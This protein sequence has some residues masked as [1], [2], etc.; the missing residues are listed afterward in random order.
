[1]HLECPHCQ[2]SYDI[3]PD[4]E[5]AVFVCHRCG[6]E[7]SATDQLSS[8]NHQPE[9]APVRKTVHIWPW[10]MAV[11]LL[12]VSSGFWL[13]KDAWL[14][15]RWFR[16]TL[17][18]IGLDMPL[19]AKDW[20]IASESV[21]SV[22]ITRN[23]GNKILLIRGNIKNLL[24]SDMLLPNIEIALFSKTAPD[25]Q[26]AVFTLE[27]SLPPSDKLIHQAPYSSPARDNMP[28]RALGNR[29]FTIVMESVPEETGDFTLTPSLRSSD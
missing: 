9:Q 18:N 24:A 17:T 15:N 25:K 14:D 19:R 27:I 1:M 8:E 3:T 4:V 28:V 10:F 12:V 29:V 21:H 2:T 23:D 26:I 5:D 20:R 13:Q 7:F 22:W 16:S 11:A 6:L